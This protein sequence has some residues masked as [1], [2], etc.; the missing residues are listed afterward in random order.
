LNTEIRTD[1]EL[2][3]RWIEPNP[4]KPRPAEAWVLP[5]HVSVW[6]VIRQLELDAWKVKCVAEGFELPVEAV[7]A[8]IRYYR[9]HRADVDARIIRNRASFD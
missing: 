1:E 4:H 9:R 3:A 5:R 7:E 6:A 2:V 8:A